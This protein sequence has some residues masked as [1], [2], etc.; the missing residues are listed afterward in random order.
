MV[1]PEPSSEPAAEPGQTQPRKRRFGTRSSATRGVILDATELVLVEQGYGAVTTRRVAERA[2]LKAPLV[3]YYY[4]TTD[5]L[6]LAVYRRA[7][8]RSV[9]RHVEAAAEADPL[10]ALWRINSDPAQTA[11]A[12]EF[13]AIANHRK[14][15]RDEIARY[16]EQIRAVEIAA[17]GKHFRALGKE[18]LPFS[19]AAL[20]VIL[21]AIGRGLVLENGVGIGLAHEEA[22]REIEAFVAGL[23]APDGPGD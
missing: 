21:A 23:S 3:H 11:L 4:K 8:E 20:T 17:L 7:A 5:D 10:R 12:L 22:R 16:A 6:L 1:R 13:M 2:G 19:P 9:E 15:I 14:F 18:S